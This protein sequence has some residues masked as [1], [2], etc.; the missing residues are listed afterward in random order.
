MAFPATYNINYYSGDTFEFVVKPKSSNGSV[1]PLTGYTTTFEIAT[2]RGQANTITGTAVIDAQAGSIT[3]TLPA[4]T[5]ATLTNATY[6]YDVDITKD[7]KVYTVLTG[8]ITITKG[9]L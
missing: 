6:V 3:C 9:V 1:F 8:T 5:G 4:S 7:G 2:A